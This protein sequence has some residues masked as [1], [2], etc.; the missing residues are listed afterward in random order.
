MLISGLIAMLI[1]KPR[2]KQFS[3]SADAFV[4]ITSYISIRGGD[5]ARNCESRSINLCHL[6]CVPSEYLHFR[7]HLHTLGV[8]V[9]VF[10]WFYAFVCVGVRA[11]GRVKLWRLTWPPLDIKRMNTS[12]LKFSTTHLLNYLK[13]WLFLSELQFTLLIKSRRF[14]MSIVKGG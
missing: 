10:A 7:E 11:C 5:K 12:Q 1:C 8:C 13:E 3:I 9:C 14:R 4:A 2:C 6:P